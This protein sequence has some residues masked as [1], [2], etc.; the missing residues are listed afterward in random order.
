MFS[1][2]VAALA[3]CGGGGAGTT[4]TAGSGGGGTGGTGGGG[5]TISGACTTSS[6][7]GTLSVQFVGTPSGAGSVMIDGATAVT[8]SGDGTLTA[9]PHTVTAFL[10]AEPGTTVRTAFTPTIDD[11]NPCVL[12]GQTTTVTVTYT[13]IPSSGLLWLGASNTPTP[14]TLFGYSPATITTSATTSATIAANTFGSDGFTFDRQ[15]NVW[16]TGGTTADPPLA[17]YPAASLGS[18]GDKTPDVTIDS[19]SFG[20]GVPGAKV[21]AFDPAGNLWVSVVAANK[22]VRFTPDQLAAGGLPMADIE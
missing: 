2:A 9:G 21:L 11:A 18:D 6:A 10:V 13:A 19:P 16:V 5:G 7:T 12:A 15:G 20:S 3:A 8:A 4:G 1:F 17:R 14:G 22:V